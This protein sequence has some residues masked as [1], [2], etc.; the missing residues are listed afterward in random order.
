MSIFFGAFQHSI[1]KQPTTTTT[2]TINGSD[3][4]QSRTGKLCRGIKCKSTHILVHGNWYEKTYT[5]L[6]TYI[7]T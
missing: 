6:D 5:N 4:N 1:G 2:T 3:K 7:Y